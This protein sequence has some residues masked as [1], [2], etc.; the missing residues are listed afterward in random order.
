MKIDFTPITR[1]LDRS[2]ADTAQSAGGL[3]DVLNLLPDAVGRLDG[4]F[5]APSTVAESDGTPTRWRQWDDSTVICKKN[6]SGAV[7]IG[8]NTGPSE[9]ATATPYRT[10]CMT[11]GSQAY[12]MSTKTDPFTDRVFLYKDSG[13]GW[14]DC[15][16]SG[17]G[18][19]TVTFNGTQRYPVN[20]DGTAPQY[21]VFDAD[22]AEGSSTS[23]I[24]ACINPTYSSGA[25]SNLLTVQYVG[26]TVANVTRAY[27][28]YG[29]DGTDT[30]AP[31]CFGTWRNRI[32]A[33]IDNEVYFGGFIGQATPFVAPDQNDWGYW[34]ELNAVTVG[35][36]GQGKIVRIEQLGDDLIVFLENATYRLYGQPPINGGTGSNQVTVDEINPTLG[37][38]DYDAV[39]RAPDGN[40]LFIAANDGQ[41]YAFNGVYNLI[42]EPVRLHPRFENIITVQCSE[43]YAIF[44]GPT[45][46]PSK[47]PYELAPNEGGLLHQNTPAFVFNTDRSTW[48]MLDQWATTGNL[49]LTPVSDP[50]NTGI[51]GAFKINDLYEICLSEPDGLHI[52][53]DRSISNPQ[54]EYTLACGLATHQIPVTPTFRADSLSVLTETPYVT[55]L[56][57]VLPAENPSGTAP[58]QQVRDVAVNTFGPTNRFGLHSSQPEPH[59]FASCAV[60]YWGEKLLNGMS[61][62]AASDAIAIDATPTVELFENTNGQH[63]NRIDVL[64]SDFDN[65]RVTI[66]ENNAG[67]LGDVVFYTECTTPQNGAVNTGTKY[68]R[69]FGINVPVPASY[70]VGL[71][72]T[73]TAY[74]YP[75]NGEI[76]KSGSVIHSGESLALRVVEEAGGC[77]SAKSIIKISAIGEGLPYDY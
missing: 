26:T 17:S 40:V 74:H 60:G 3:R 38:N 62:Y 71:T 5:R 43:K 2:V 10:V 12:V 63:V 30:F 55:R 19:I 45:I 20:A 36:S 32:C 77:Y 52:V 42:S 57:G 15:T 9:T 53:N 1:G 59:N 76:V 58:F 7:Q 34:Y 73:C 27:I 21:I 47:V 28:V 75:N 56:S 46:D 65:C 18:T 11:T 54:L 33:G 49:T 69:T 68:W 22:T 14:G 48:S 44:T 37:I 51:F 67:V 16:L 29:D 24:R 72:G 64:L 6:P 31:D 13:T 41:G 4:I 23:K 25:T 66:Y 61:Y 50:H 8:S 70:W 39:G 35:H